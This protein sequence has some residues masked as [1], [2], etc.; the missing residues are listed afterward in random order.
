MPSRRPLPRPRALS[1][2][3]SRSTRTLLNNRPTVRVDD[4][5]QSDIDAPRAVQWMD[6]DDGEN[7]EPVGGD[8]NGQMSSE[9]LK[10]SLLSLP[11]GSLRRAQRTLAQDTLENNVLEGDGDDDLRSESETSVTGPTKNSSSSSGKQ[12]PTETEKAKRQ[13]VNKHAPQEVT[14]KR[15]VSR[16]RQIVK[17]QKMEVRDPRF[18]ATVSMSDA[19][20]FRT[21]YSFLADLQ[22]NELEMLREHLQRARS[23]LN[24]S[25]RNLR[26]EREHEVERLERAFKRAESSVD[27]DKRVHIEHEALARA[28]NEEKDKRKQ[29]KRAFYLKSADKKRLL[30]NARYDAMAVEGGQRAI[31]KAIEK[32]QKKMSQ[33]ETKSRPFPLSDNLTGEPKHRSESARRNGSQNKRRRLD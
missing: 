29:G 31:K 33:K 17:V 13:R 14:S 26:E 24:S 6:E 12:R 3:A 32:K 2:R 18:H 8:A 4:I 27:R 20:M 28:T 10:N 23:L 1:S 25:P 22:K 5:D 11:F 16:H 21:Q 30:L 19:E 9:A 15:P 7:N